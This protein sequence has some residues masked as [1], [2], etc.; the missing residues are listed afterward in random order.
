MTFNKEKK[1][2]SSQS[3]S[4]FPAEIPAPVRR[5]HS[6]EVVKTAAHTERGRGSCLEQVHARQLRLLGVFGCHI[7]LLSFSIFSGSGSL[8]FGECWGQMEVRVPIL[9]RPPAGTEKFPEEACFARV[10]GWRHQCWT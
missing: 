8:F 4:F 2:E 9:P 6:L 3:R 7:F 10:L 1:A 5:N